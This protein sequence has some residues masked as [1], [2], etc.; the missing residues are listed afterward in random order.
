[1]R[2]YCSD[3]LSLFFTSF[4]VKSSAVP[5][6]SLGCI[7]LSWKEEGEQEKKEASTEM[8]VRQQNMSTCIF[9]LM[10]FFQGLILAA[11]RITASFVWSE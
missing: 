1:M 9:V 3:E 4:K 11:H 7:S 10:P 6:P 5:Q 2:K 8:Q